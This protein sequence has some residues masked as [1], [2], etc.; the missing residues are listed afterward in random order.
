MVLIM[1]NFHNRPR[2]RDQRHS[3][4]RSTMQIHMQDKERCKTSEIW[5]V[6]KLWKIFSLLI[7]NQGALE[8]NFEK[9]SIIILKKYQKFFEQTGAFLLTFAQK[10]LKIVWIFLKI[11]LPNFPDSMFR[12]K[13]ISTKFFSLP[14]LLSV[15]IF[16]YT[17]MSDT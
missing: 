9:I 11:C 2:K 12:S 14:N 4:R 17:H 7:L 13:I 6:K 3:S 5:V 8:K 16:L 1:K 10:F 15:C